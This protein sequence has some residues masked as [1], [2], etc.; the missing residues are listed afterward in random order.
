MDGA[1]D[2]GGR[3]VLA[4]V[5]GELPLIIFVMTLLLSPSDFLRLLLLC[6][7]TVSPKFG[8]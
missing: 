3:L 8:E 2:V 7:G 6:I 1:F 5:G 4:G